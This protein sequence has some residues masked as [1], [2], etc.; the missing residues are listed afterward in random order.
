MYVTIWEWSGAHYVNTPEGVQTVCPG[1]FH[2][3]KNL[4]VL[5]KTRPTKSIYFQKCL[6]QKWISYL[7]WTNLFM[8]RTCKIGYVKRVRTWD[9]NYIIYHVNIPVMNIHVIYL[10][11]FSPTTVASVSTNLPRTMFSW[12]SSRTMCAMFAT[13]ILFTRPMMLF[14]R[15]SQEILWYSALVL[16]SICCCIMR[17][18]AGGM[19]APPVRVIMLLSSAF[20]ALLA[21]RKLAMSSGSSPPSFLSVPF[22]SSSPC[23]EGER[24][25]FLIHYITNKRMLVHVYMQCHMCQW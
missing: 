15:A 9:F 11:M 19:Y 18:R 5:T 8:V 6:H 3:N 14:L 7:W 1:L 21:A 17:S 22:L 4:I 2:F 20:F 25:R 24:L 13:L 12:K 10:L 16:S 23:A